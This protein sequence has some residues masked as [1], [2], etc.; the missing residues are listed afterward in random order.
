[1]SRARFL[2]RMRSQSNKNAKLS[3]V[4][5]ITRRTYTTNTT[6]F[7]PVLEHPGI[8]G[9]IKLVTERRSFMV[10]LVDTKRYLP[11]VEELYS[12][13]MAIIGVKIN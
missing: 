10:Q 13:R 4:S 9:A 3:P 1:M 8:P 12:T 6:L 7:S 11:V 2:Q 5:A